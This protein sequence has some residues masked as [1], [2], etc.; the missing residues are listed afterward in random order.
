MNAA[1]ESCLR[2][3]MQ[4]VWRALH[5]AR[6]NAGSSMEARIAMMAMTTSSSMSVKALRPFPGR[7]AFC[8]DDRDIRRL[9]L[10]QFY[11]EELFRLR[12]G[13]CVRR[14]VQIC[15]PWSGDSCCLEQRSLRPCQAH[16]GAD[17]L[18]VQR[19][20]C[21]CLEKAEHVSGRE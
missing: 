11:S 15:V 6:A 18:D 9:D 19:D 21:S 7:R 12:G 4:P 20:A 13:K 14:N 16:I 2:L 1:V 5:L 3:L 17:F 10:L 8:C